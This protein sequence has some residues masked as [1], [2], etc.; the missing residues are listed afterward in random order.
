MIRDLPFV[1]KAFPAF[2]EIDYVKRVVALPGDTV[3]LIN[4]QVYL[5]GEMIYEPFAKGSTY[6]Q[7]IDFPITVP[8]GK[9]FVLGD[10]RSIS[11][12]SRQIGLIE[13]NRIKGRAIFRIWPFESIGG[14][15]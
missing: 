8:A 14:L 12:D 10:N 6:K 7:S 9:V 2:S 13:F 1:K 5:N 3:D 15:E 11:R 4:G